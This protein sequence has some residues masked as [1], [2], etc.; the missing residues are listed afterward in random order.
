M[1]ECYFISFLNNYRFIIHIKIHYSF[2]M[3]IIILYIEFCSQ[4]LHLYVRELSEISQNTVPINQENIYLFFQ[5]KIIPTNVFL[6]RT[7]TFNKMLIHQY[8]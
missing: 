8:Q 7:N 4:I 1:H 5:S 6:L 3:Q 2:F